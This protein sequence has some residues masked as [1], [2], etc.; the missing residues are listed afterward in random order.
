ML[1]LLWIYRFLDWRR[2]LA[3]LLV[4]RLAERLR[5]VDFFVVPLAAAALL[6]LLPMNNLIIG[7]ICCIVD[8][9]F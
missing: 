6:P 2:V 7:A 5:V 9:N 4:G 1:S 3:F 8:I